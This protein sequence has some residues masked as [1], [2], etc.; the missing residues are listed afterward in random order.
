MKVA[1][2]FLL[3]GCAAFI[4]VA[5]RAT[6]ADDRNPQQKASPSTPEA[7]RPVTANKRT[8]VSVPVPKPANPHRAI[9][10]PKGAAAD[11]TARGRQ[12][13]SGVRNS[14]VNAGP[15]AMRN[16][17]KPPVVRQST[18][19][20]PVEPATSNLRHHGANPPTIGGPRKTTTASLSGRAVSRKP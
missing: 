13:I 11:K 6:T 15:S 8:H 1:L 9:H 2:F 7:H 4:G 5:A 16:T 14:S 20:R 17:P 12:P 19:S 10:N 3:L 18:I